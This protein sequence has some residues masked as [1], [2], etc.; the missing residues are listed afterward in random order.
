[1]FYGRNHKL[2]MQVHWYNCHRISNTLNQVV[3]IT[4]GTEGG[5]AIDLL[6]LGY[7]GL[8]KLLEEYSPVAYRR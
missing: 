6:N 5:V 4:S 2:Q 7:G 1:M 8:V 3:G